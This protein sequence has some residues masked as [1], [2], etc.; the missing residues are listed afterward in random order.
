M[1]TTQQKS[2]GSDA[3]KRAQTQDN[4]RSKPTAT[5][6]A[7]QAAEQLK[8]LTS[9]DVESV[10]GLE[11]DEDGWTVL[12]EVVES[13]RIPDSADILALYE[14]HVDSQAEMT[15]YRRLRRYGRGHTGDD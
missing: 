1:A 10:T 12:L 4:K 11:R 14:V 9:R 7:V 3:S 6:I 2:G 15:G 5:Q 8:Q 13:R